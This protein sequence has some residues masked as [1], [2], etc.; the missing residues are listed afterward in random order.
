MCIRDRVGATRNE[1]RR[2]RHNGRLAPRL[3]ADPLHRG[4][5]EPPSELPPKGSRAL[6]ERA[7][8]KR[9]GAAP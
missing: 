3:R 5:M 4:L 9:L 7:L 8:T 1:V 2:P 6:G